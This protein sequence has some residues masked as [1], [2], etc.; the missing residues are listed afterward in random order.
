VPEKRKKTHSVGKKKNRTGS[1]SSNPRQVFLCKFKE[2]PCRKIGE[3]WGFA[4]EPLGKR[5]SCK[6]RQGGIREAKKTG[7]HLGGGK[8]DNTQEKKR[9][10]RPYNGGNV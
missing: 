2:R 9:K 4:R 1:V 7:G 8:K 10:K 5:D 3:I 6:D